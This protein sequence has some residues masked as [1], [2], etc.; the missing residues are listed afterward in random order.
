MS[1][2]LRSPI[3]NSQSADPELEHIRAEL[4]QNPALMGQADKKHPITQ[5]EFAKAEELEFVAGLTTDL[6]FTPQPRP[7]LPEMKLA[8]FESVIAATAKELPNSLMRVRTALEQ[9]KLR[10]NKNLSESEF[11]RTLAQV[12]RLFNHRQTH[13]LSM[14]LRLRLAQQILEQVANPNLVFQGNHGT[15]NVAAGAEIYTYYANPSQAAKLVVDIA[16][17]GRYSAADGTEVS[18]DNHPHGTS[19][20]QSLPPGSR[21]YASELF[22]V[23]AANLF[24]EKANLFLKKSKIDAEFKYVQNAETATKDGEGLYYN[25]HYIANNDDLNIAAIKYISKVINNT[26]YDFPTWLGSENELRDILQKHFGSTSVPMPV[27]LFVHNGMFETSAWRNIGTWQ[28]ESDNLVGHLV[29]VSSFDPQADTVKIKDASTDSQTPDMVSVHDLF[30]DM[31]PLSDNCRRIQKAQDQQSV[32]G[33]VN[34]LDELTL[35]TLALEH[36]QVCKTTKDPDTL[37]GDALEH[38]NNGTTQPLTAPQREEVAAIA[39]QI[40]EE[41]SDY[42]E[43]LKMLKTAALLFKDGI[44]SQPDYERRLVNVG[45][46]VHTSFRSELVGK[47]VAD[48]EASEYIHALNLLP[49]SNAEYIEAMVR[50]VLE[51]QHFYRDFPEKQ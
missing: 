15:C 47:D 49:R 29:D 10:T 26:D 3:E 36:S 9:L 6:R 17:T 22:Q 7:A 45:Y 40:F 23:T 42:Y 46:I 18:I 51:P 41:R 20:L 34:I 43:P 8:N 30:I 37:L 50:E 2:D 13:P 33:K 32:M 12:A 25:G 11:N 39:H 16:T 31:N 1:D 14:E 5:S 4:N 19:F 38:L 44:L 35:A 27:P 28:L 48:A 24:W 21:S